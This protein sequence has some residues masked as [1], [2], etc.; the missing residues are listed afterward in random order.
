VYNSLYPVLDA[1]MPVAE[2]AWVPCNQDIRPATMKDEGYK[3]N[4]T[5]KQ[6]SMP[7]LWHHPLL[8]QERCPH[9]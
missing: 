5:D 9:V 1:T 2:R 8:H 6:K 4:K 7:Y 3:L